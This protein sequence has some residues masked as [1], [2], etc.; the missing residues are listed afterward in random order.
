MVRPA[1]ESEPFREIR[2]MAA[3]STSRAAPRATSAAALDGPVCGRVGGVSI[4]S[5]TKASSV[6]DDEGTVVLE[7]TVVELVAVDEVVGP[8]ALVVELAAVD[9][10]V[11]PV[12]EV[13]VVELPP[14]VEVV[15]AEVVEVVEL[16]LVVEVAGAEVDV[17]EVAP[18]VEVVE[19]AVVLVVD[20]GGG[21]DVEGATLVVVLGGVGATTVM[22]FESVDPF[23]GS[24]RSSFHCVARACVTKAQ[25]A[26][27]ASVVTVKGPNRSSVALSV[28]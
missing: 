2:Y 13:E 15:P 11:G 21:V 10:V 24:T 4:C 28:A 16:P 14:V 22:T 20:V 9:E 23:P 3:P 26:P 7:T 8:V 17:V 5:N 18:V 12:L 6:A 25:N 1:R 27:V 19:G